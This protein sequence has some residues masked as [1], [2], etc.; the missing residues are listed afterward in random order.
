MKFTQEQIEKNLAE[1]RA[2]KDHKRKVSLMPETKEMLKKL[3]ENKNA[4]LEK[5]Y[6]LLCYRGGVEKI[7]V[8]MCADNDDIST[9]HK[10]YASFR[11]FINAL[12]GNDVDN[13]LA[14]DD[15]EL[16]KLV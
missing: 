11:A 12:D 8:L 13:V 3:I 16:A 5:R 4:F 15:E 2:L 14:L 9:N 6:E 10:D 1:F 7:I